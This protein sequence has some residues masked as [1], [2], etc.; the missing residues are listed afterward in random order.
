MSGM[1]V[2]LK[3][4]KNLSEEERC[5]LKAYDIPVDFTRRENIKR[6]IEYMKE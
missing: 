6:L 1:K 3:L 4:K 2:F 5:M